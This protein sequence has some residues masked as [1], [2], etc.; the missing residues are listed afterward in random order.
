M[1]PSPEKAAKKTKNK[2]K[3]KKNITAELI[4]QQP[5]SRVNEDCGTCMDQI[6]KQRSEA[7]KTGYSLVLTNIAYVE[8]RTLPPRKNGRER[9]LPPVFPR[10]GEG[11][12]ALRL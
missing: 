12:A 7:E 10:G 3:N 4:L 11:T 8:P 1:Q 5:R 9:S 2:N 6:Q